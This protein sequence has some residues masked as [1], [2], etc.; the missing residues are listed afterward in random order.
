MSLGL[1][2]R[3][4]KQKRRRQFFMG[5]FKF[6]FFVGSCVGIGYYAQQFGLSMAE[7]EVLVWKTRFENQQAENE[8]LKVELGQD[9]A[10]LDQMRQLLP[11]EDMLQVIAAVTAK[12]NEGVELNRMQNIIS[13]IAKDAACDADIDSKRFMVLTPVSPDEVST[14]S[15][16]RGLITVSGIGSSVMNENGAPEAWFDPAKE[17][18]ISFMLPGG[19]K[20]DIEGT[21][22]LYHSVITGGS[23]YRFSITAGRTS[24]ADASVQRCDL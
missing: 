23:E 10:E 1:V 21:L 7:E 8:K 17:V 5:V 11:N 20:Q 2:H 4:E 19:E 6:L 22:P 12:A 18:T 13:G 9:K 14:A 15:Y 3:K 24:F 16:Y